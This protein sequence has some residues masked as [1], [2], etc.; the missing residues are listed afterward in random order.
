MTTSPLANPGATRA[1][2]ETYGLA[3]KHRLGQ[4]F[5]IDNHVIEKIMD[6][7]ALE[8]S[9]RVVEVGP[10]IGTLTLALLQ[11]AARV[12]SIEADGE[13]EPVLRTHAL[14]H[15]NF[16]YIM[17]DALRVAPERIAEAC[18]G[19]PEILVANLPYN[20]AAT[21]I[22]QFFQTMPDLRSAVVM[23]QKEVADRIAAHPGTKTYGGYTAK[24]G[25]YAG[26]T[27]RFEVPPRCFMPAPHVDSA[28]VRLDR[29]EVPLAS[30][31]SDVDRICEVID[32]AFAQRRKTIRNSMSASGFDKAALDA[33]FNACGIA[34]TARAET[35]GVED[36]VRLA[37]CLSGK[38]REDNE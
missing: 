9:E 20:V 2:L 33:A 1:L 23:V 19:A 16:A 12:V 31:A 25:L 22:L 35:L 21:I 14:E 30:E 26:V 38:W 7:A 18:G 6:L 27:G 15:D 4:N 29:H 37:A 3:T 10:G 5:L 24:L 28:V 11:D 34:P 17:G 32:A 8:G 36:F 13:L